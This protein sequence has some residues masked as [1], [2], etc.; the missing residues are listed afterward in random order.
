VKYK[1][2]D[3]ESCSYTTRRYARNL[4]EVGPAWCNAP[5]ADEPPDLADRIVVGASLVAAIAL[6]VMSAVG[7]VQ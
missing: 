6:L 2:T 7:W 3:D 1:I 5:W 4:N